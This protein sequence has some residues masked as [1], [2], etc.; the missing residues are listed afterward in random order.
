[1]TADTRDFRFDTDVSIPSQPASPALPGSQPGGGIKADTGKPRMDLIPPEVLFALAT[2]LGFGA[3]KYAV[4]NWELGMSWGR[5]F[6]AL[7][8]HMWA[9]WGGQGPTTKSFAFGDLDLET[10]FSHL[11]HALCCIAFLVAYEQRGVGE[12]DRLKV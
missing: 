10:G 11:W 5:V 4:R 3:E 6:G 1:M 8:R 7:M 12:D 9:W 2:V